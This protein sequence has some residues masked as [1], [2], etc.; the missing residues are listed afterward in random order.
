MSAAAPG[1]VLLAGG[2]TAGH[3]SP[4]LALAD[5]LR[6]RDPQVR[7]AA[8][9]T[10]EG[11]EARL[12]P[13]RGYP[14]HE[15]PRV[16]FPRR[17][18][19]AALRLPGDLRRAVAAAERALEQSAAEVVVGFGGFV[20]SPAYLA[21]R[22]RRVPVVV[23]EQN[24][25]PGLANRLGARVA[26][27][28]AVT[29]PGTPLRGATVT[30][31]PLRHEIATLD[32]AALRAEAREHFG[33]AEGPTL[34]VTGGSLGAARLNGAFAAAAAE[35]S[36]AGVQVLHVTGAGK[37]VDPGPLPGARYVVL[38]YCDRMDLAYAAADLVVARSGANTVCELT[39]VGLPAVYVPLPI[40]NGEQRLNVSHVLDAGGGL[41]V[42]DALVDARWVGDV[43]LPLAQDEER[44]AAMGRAAS[45]VGQR[46]GDE[47][48]ADLVARAAGGR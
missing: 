30:G 37:E 38:P 35:L 11:L 10:A 48:L 26:A 8:L 9:G 15:V 2:G 1:S 20:A 17:P 29:F 5:C 25:R 33:L 12:V 22:R 45:S 34:L 32:R 47:R 41:V 36:A 19:A 31:M 21:A 46:D 18:D 23:H 28:V 16:P 3:V 39:A 44:V 40:G 6:R 42:D 4:L 13:A 7:V 43:V 27:E 14:L 24:A